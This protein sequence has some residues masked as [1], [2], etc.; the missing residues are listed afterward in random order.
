[1]V[2]TTNGQV[3]VQQVAERGWIVRSDVQPDSIANVLG[4]I[5]Q[6][7][8]GFEL[9]VVGGD[10]HWLTFSS[11]DEAVEHLRVRARAVQPA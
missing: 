10:F 9:M 4:C 11:L 5:E 3:R 7:D 8:E 6:R 2:L 1:M